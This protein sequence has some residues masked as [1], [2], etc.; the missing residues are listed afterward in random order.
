MSSA[1]KSATKVVRSQTAPPPSHGRPAPSATSSS[2]I[3]TTINL[4]VPRHEVVN[5]ANGAGPSGASHTHAHTTGDASEV[6][7][8]RPRELQDRDFKVKEILDWRLDQDG[9]VEYLVIWGSSWVHRDQIQWRGT[10]R[11]VF[12]A[13]REWAILRTLD[14]CK[15]D[16]I[17]VAWENSWRPVYKLPNAAAAID[18]YE[19]GVDGTT[20][21]V[22]K[23]HHTHKY[24]VDRV[25][26][27]GHLPRGLRP[28]LGKPT[29]C[30]EGQMD[31]APAF[32]AFIEAQHGNAAGGGNMPNY[33]SMR[34]RRGLVFDH[35]FVDDEETMDFTR[36]DVRSSAMLYIKGMVQPKPCDHCRS[37]PNN[38][39]PFA[40]CVT[41]PYYFHKGACAN[42]LLLRKTTACCYHVQNRIALASATDVVDVSDDDETA[43]D[44]QHPS[45]AV[46]RHGT[47]ADGVMVDAP[48]PGQQLRLGQ[49]PGSTDHHEH[50]A[51]RDLSMTDNV[52]A[53]LEESDGDADDPGDYDYQ[54]PF[55]PGSHSE[56]EPGTRS[57]VSQD[58]AEADSDWDSGMDE[59]DELLGHRSPR[60]DRR[61]RVLEYAGTSISTPQRPVEV[62]TRESIR[63]GKR[64]VPP[65]PAEPQPDMSS[66][67]TLAADEQSSPGL[68][69]TRTPHQVPGT[70]TSTAPSSQPPT[71]S[72]STTQPRTALGLLTASATNA[73]PRPAPQSSKRR[74]EE[75][76]GDGPF[77]SQSHPKK[78]RRKCKPTTPSTGQAL[79]MAGAS[80]QLSLRPA[81]VSDLS[82][83]ASTTAP[84]HPLPAPASLT[85]TTLSAVAMPHPTPTAQP[86]AAPDPSLSAAMQ[87]AIASADPTRTNVWNEQ[88][89]A[90]EVR[91][92][93]SVGRVR[94]ILRCCDQTW[95][96][97]L[98]SLWQTNVV[99]RRPTF[100]LRT[101]ED[102]LALP[103][104]DILN[105]V[106]RAHG[107]SQPVGE[108]VDL[109]GGDD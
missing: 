63:R 87:A 25:Y 17:K 5:A 29:F 8:E 27:M 30:P 51:H 21:G 103:F 34:T 69:Q 42:C 35:T 67:Q 105:V 19:T 3:R 70:P 55:C 11:F 45:P 10:R 101:I 33:L 40:Q 84:R 13:D 46:S 36:G 109:T 15:P 54:L 9:W 71:P 28:D 108:V 61:P 76:Q 57:P 59:S 95:Q 58:N 99:E 83:Q 53:P 92:R 62:H 22:L 80:I 23:P 31:Y 88:F 94:A 93:A 91:A 104:R 49:S 97:R 102:T 1:R 24:D 68:A 12:C 75:G 86:V 47:P 43:Q 32:L 41:S 74:R 26:P 78:A 107:T 48:D 73:R 89:G 60:D 96:R 66:S 100:A 6:K 50:P 20:P 7:S 77:D 82:A 106:I 81:T 52:L 64:P 90:T 38:A 44:D 85:S 37:T 16:T 79:S 39:K 56:V 14:N 2:S 72:H 98:D 18:K 4:A 65:D